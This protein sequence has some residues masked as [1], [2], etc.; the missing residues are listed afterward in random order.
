VN[1]LVANEP[2]AFFSTGTGKQ[3]P[4][5]G[6]SAHQATAQSSVGFGDPT[7]FDVLA[8]ISQRLSARDLKK[9]RSVCKTWLEVADHAAAVRPPSFQVSH[10]M[11]NQDDIDGGFSL[12]RTFSCFSPSQSSHPHLDSA[13]HMLMADYVYVYNAACGSFGSHVYSLAC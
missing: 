12:F 1:E 13:I 7:F 11:L 3:A 5:F 9:C 10:H 8:V 6:G 4:T 2:I